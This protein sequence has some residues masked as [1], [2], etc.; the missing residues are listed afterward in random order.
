MEASASFK[1]AVTSSES[2]GCPVLYIFIDLL[3]V[4]NIVSGIVL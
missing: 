3:S 1:M 4:W 2:T